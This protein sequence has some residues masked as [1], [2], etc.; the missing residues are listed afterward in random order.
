MELPSSG[1]TP[2]PCPQQA[3]FQDGY[4]PEKS[5]RRTGPLEGPDFP[6]EDR[7]MPNVAS[8]LVK[9]AIARQNCAE[10]GSA[11]GLPSLSFTLTESGKK[12][13][14]KATGVADPLIQSDEDDEFAYH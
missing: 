12:K 6:L 8:C 10:L 1:T 3:L 13:K 2:T 9:I 11:H 7:A 4:P 14:K 5:S